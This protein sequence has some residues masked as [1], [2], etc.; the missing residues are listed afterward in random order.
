M[1]ESD[2]LDP[3]LAARRRD[4]VLGAI[5]RNLGR[6]AA[7]PAPEFPMPPAHPR[8]AVPEEDLVERWRKRWEARVSCSSSW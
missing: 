5:R 1:S 4:T 6:D 7:P 3:A 8:L 2:P